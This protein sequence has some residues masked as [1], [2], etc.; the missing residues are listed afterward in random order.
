MVKKKN[1]TQFNELTDFV[2]KP[3]M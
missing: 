2:A 3:V 1:S